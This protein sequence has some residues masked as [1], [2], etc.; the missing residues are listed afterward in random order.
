MTSDAAASWPSVSY[1][2]LPWRV[3]QT[4]GTASRAEIRRH[5]GPYRA[6]IVPAI[7]GSDI[8]L[9]SGVLAEAEDASAEMARF[10]AE[11]GSEVAPFGAVLLRSESVASSE[12]ENLSASARAIAEAE[13]GD[14]SRRNASQIVANVQAMEAAIALAE[15]IDAE[16]ILRM[17]WA[18]MH[19]V[20]PVAGRFRDQQVWIG[21]GSL[22]PQ[23]AMFIPPH[24]SRVPAAIADLI[25]FV[26]RDEIPVLVH[27]ALAHA[28]FE[29]IHPFTDGNGRTGRALLHSMLRHK[30]LTRN[31]TVPVSAGLLTDT[32]AYFT[33]LDTYRTGDPSAIVGQLARAT[34]QAIANGRVLVGELRAIRAGWNPRLSVRRDSAT[35]R[36]V[37]L[38]LR[39]PVINTGLVT[40]ELAITSRNVNRYIE[41]IAAAGILTEFTDKR[42]N[43]AWRSVEVL[44]A[45]DAFAARAGRRSA[46]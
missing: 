28:Q 38:L 34:L 15:R 2:T 40:R 14:T 30:S 42:R 43:R 32:A 18:L 31:V 19:E 29:T 41:P 37:D 3:E 27:A 23:R 4:P 46:V 25:A 22:G 44:Q 7:A 20:D 17:H 21:G 24:H 33:A 26:E 39:H 45:L 1:E 12:I 35:W 6:A 5:A 13:I 10:D 11:V 9:P 36:V 16:S 8:Q